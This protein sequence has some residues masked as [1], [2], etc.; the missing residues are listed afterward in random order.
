MNANVVT[1][2][3]L[4]RAKIP[5]V[6]A[7]DREA[8]ETAIRCNWDVRAEETRFVRIPNTLHLEHAYL[9]ENLVDEALAN[10]NVE[11]VGEPAEPKF[12][13]DGHFKNF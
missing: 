7:N 2:T 13:E 10:S 8:L 6:V 12:D 11:I 4:E 3:F 9:S 5:M 1:S